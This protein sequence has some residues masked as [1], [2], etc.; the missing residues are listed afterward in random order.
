[1]IY[2]DSRYAD[3]KIYRAY[4]KSSDSYEVTVSRQFPQKTSQFFVYTCTDSDR[5]DQ[6]SMKFYGNSHAWWKIMDFN[7]DVIDP[8]HLVAGTILRIPRGI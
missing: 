2:T 8:F 4:R 3:G 7:P 6:I 1:M 5:I